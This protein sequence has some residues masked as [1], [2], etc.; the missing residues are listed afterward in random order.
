MHTINDRGKALILLPMVI[1]FILTQAACTTWRQTQD[2]RINNLLLRFEWNAESVKVG[3]TIQMR[4]IAENTGQSPIVYESADTPVL[5]ITVQEVHSPKLVLSWSSQNPDKAA[6][7]IEWGAFERKVL[8]LQWTPGDDFQYGR[9]VHIGG[10][11][12]EN[13]R[14]IKSVGTTICAGSTSTCH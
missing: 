2:A 13:S 3:E 6:H 8:E 12:S 14:I 4:F 1:L 10:H 7:R 5:D 9:L 11:L